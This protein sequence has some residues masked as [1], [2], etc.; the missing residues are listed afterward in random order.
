MPV[1]VI[2]GIRIMRRLQWNAISMTAEIAM[3]GMLKPNFQT[4]KSRVTE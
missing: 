2:L 4:I 1:N 3:I